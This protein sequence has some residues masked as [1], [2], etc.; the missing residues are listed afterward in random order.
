MGLGDNSDHAFGPVGGGIDA[1][2]EADATA[3]QHRRP[4]SVDGR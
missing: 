4:R 1:S 2:A 3:A